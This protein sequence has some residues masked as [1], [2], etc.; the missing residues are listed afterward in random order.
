MSKARSLANRSNDTIS[1]SDYSPVGDGVTDDSVAVLAF[2]NAASGKTALVP[3]KTFYIGN[4]AGGALSVAL[5]NCNLIGVPGLSQFKFGI[6]VATGGNC[7]NFNNPSDVSIYGIVFNDGRTYATALAGATIT[8]NGNMKNVVFEKCTFTGTLINIQALCFFVNT[9]TSVNGTNVLNNVKVKNCFFN[10]VGNSAVTLMNRQPAANANRYTVCS[11]FYMQDN[12]ATGLGTQGSYGML[13]SLDGFG[14]DWFIERNYLSGGYAQMIENTN[15]QSGHIKDNH[16]GACPAGC[17]F[18][19]FNN[20]ITNNY[21]TNIIISGNI[22]DSPQTLQTNLTQM[23]NCVIE[24]NY[25]SS[26]GAVPP[27]VINAVSN[28]QF[29][30]NTYTS[31]GT[32]ENVRM[33]AV[34][35]NIFEGDQFVNTYA[36]GGVATNIYSPSALTSVAASSGNKFIGCTF[37]NSVSSS[38]SAPLGFPDSA[39]VNNYAINCTFNKGTGGYNCVPPWT[40]ASPSCYLVNPITN[41]ASIFN[42]ASTTIGIPDAN[43]TYT[44]SDGLAANYFLITGSPTAT[45]T[46]TMPTLPGNL[47]FKN[48]TGQSVSILM[49]AGSQTIATN[50]T[51]VLCWNGTQ[52]QRVTAD[53]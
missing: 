35:N 4:A 51:A 52:M 39:A 48:Q 30:N 23:S 34:Q 49:G 27:V 19:S 26:T 29:R 16:I 47:A 6:T 45:R 41:N 37:D 18:M 5:A 53:N 33:Y 40:G 11:G 36:T 42:L 20:T 3:G 46:I 50:K 25:F 7:I 38:N 9:S 2:L 14:I 8:A 10:Q 17:S 32:N 21:L 31:S 43:Y 1:L 22:C 28:C 15:F 13:I 12:Y 24:N 44:S